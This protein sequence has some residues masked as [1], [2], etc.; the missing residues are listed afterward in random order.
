MRVL[1]YGFQRA[2]DASRAQRALIE[3]CHLSQRDA[4]IAELADDGVVLGVRAP[5][6]ALDEIRAILDRLGGRRLTDIDER[7]T[8]VTPRHH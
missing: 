8:G 5:E 1:G 2:A 3:E 4:E 6:E 7:W